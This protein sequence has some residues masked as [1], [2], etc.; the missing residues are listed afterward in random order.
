MMRVWKGG[1]QPTAAA[2]AAAVI[3]RLY[4]VQLHITHLT[5]PV[6]VTLSVGTNAM[7]HLRL[8]FDSTAVRLLIKSSDGN[9]TH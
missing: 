2:A 4:D 3:N 7:S 9:R 8:D 5:S 6:A 1:S